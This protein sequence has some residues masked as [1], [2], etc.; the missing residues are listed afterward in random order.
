MRQTADRPIAAQ[1][2]ERTYFRNSLLACRGLDG[3]PDEVVVAVLNSCL[4][5]LFYRVT[6]QES[7]QKAFPQVKIK[8]LH[9]LPVFD[10]YSLDRPAEGDPDSSAQ[11]RIVSLVHQLST[12]CRRG[13]C[14]DDEQE[15]GISLERLILQL[16]GLPP[17]IAPAL[18]ERTYGT[19]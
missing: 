18:W 19:A 2:V 8:Y 7:A 5:C 14:L 4:I 17:D 3:V 9:Q 16:Y 15:T 1:H 10:G 11:S 12:R 13:S 6:V